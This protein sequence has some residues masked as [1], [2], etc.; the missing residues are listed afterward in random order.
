MDP[1]R[2]PAWSPFFNAEC[3]VAAHS[4]PTL[5]CMN[6]NSA[7]SS[8]LRPSMALVLGSLLAFVGL[9]LSVLTFGSQGHRLD[10]DQLPAQAQAI[11]MERY[12]DSAHPDPISSD[13][14]S[15]VEKVM[16]AQGGWS[17]ERDLTL[18]T[19]RKGWP[20]F[21]LLPAVTLIILRIKRRP[22][23]FP[24]A[25]LLWVPSAGLA[26]WAQVVSVGRLLLG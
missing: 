15:R 21:L 26:I 3:A 19:V 18:L 10:F 17:S 1:Q 6:S 13:Q 9:L 5:D 23:S 4:R 2:R 20:F 25:I 14:W 7:G 16:Q 12:R 8:T 11:L 22:I 24:I